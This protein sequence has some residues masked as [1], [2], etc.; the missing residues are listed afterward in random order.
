MLILEQERSQI[1]ILENQKK[2][3]GIIHEKNTKKK[4]VTIK[5]KVNKMIKRQ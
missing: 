2:N 3:K 1:S 4:I 5:I